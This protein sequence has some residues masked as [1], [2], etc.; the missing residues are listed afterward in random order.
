MKGA[1]VSGIYGTVGPL[2]DIPA[3][4]QASSAPARHTYR[5]QTTTLLSPPKLFEFAGA[6]Y[7]HAVQELH[8]AS[9]SMFRDAL[10][11]AVTDCVT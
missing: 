10:Y 1:D 6:I 7:S 11:V 2:L 8:G 3:F 4:R 9:V 5:P